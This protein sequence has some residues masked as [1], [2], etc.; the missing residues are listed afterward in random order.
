MFTYSGDPS[1][2]SLDKV[3]FLISDTDSTDYELE[4][5]EVQFVIDSWATVYDAAIAAA[6]IIA[7]KY[8]TKT[9]YSR[10]IGDLSIS[11]AYGQAA[12][13]YRSL[14]DRLRHQKAL[15][16]PPSPRINPQ[17]ILPTQE[18]TV[19]AYKSDFYTGLMDNNSI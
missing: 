9:N 14:A 11:E 15:L 19:T 8:A 5:S 1:A 2:S 16:N 18:K 10:S 4:D 12:T 13:E 17:A 3:R 7:G 6:E